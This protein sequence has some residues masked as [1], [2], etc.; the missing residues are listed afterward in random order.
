MRD[1]EPRPRGC[2]HFVICNAVADRVISPHNRTIVRVPAVVIA[3]IAL[4]HPAVWTRSRLGVYRERRALV[5]SVATYARDTERDDDGG[6]SSA[7]AERATTYTCHAVRNGDGCQAAATVESTVPYARHAARD[8]DR[9]QTCATAE[10]LTFYALDAAR[11]GYVLQRCTLMKRGAPDRCQPGGELYVAQPIAVVE[12][13]L[14]YRP[15]R[16][17]HFH[18]DERCAITECRPADLRHSVGNGDGGKPFASEEHI[19][20]YFAQCIRQCDRC[21][22]VGRIENESGV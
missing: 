14:F 16:V 10:S 1:S 15:D 18:R 19:V 20:A 5:K 22:L 11:Y 9:S 8:G 7:S 17:R 4:I 6:K 21:H 3:V 13:F 2:A 12:G